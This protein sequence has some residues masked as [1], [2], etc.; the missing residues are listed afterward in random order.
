MKLKSPLSLLVL[1]LALVGLAVFTYAQG[2]PAQG[3]GGGGADAGGDVRVAMVSP[4]RIFKA[5]RETKD[6]GESMESEGIRLR[7]EE[8]ERRAKI[9]RLQDIRN[10]LKPESAQWD[11]AQ[12]NLLKAA[13]D[14]DTWGK[15]TKAKAERNQKRQMKHLF[16]Q[17]ERAVAEVAERDGYDLVLADQRPKLDNLDEINF[18][19]LQALLT[20]RNVLYASAKADISD[21][22]IALLDAKY[23]GAAAAPAGGAGAGAAAP[24]A[25]AGAPAPARGKQNPAPRQGGAPAGKD[26]AA[27][28]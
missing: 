18:N 13:I 12:E 21:Q 3:G 8:D 2:Q 10:D 22:V 7:A 28:D 15:L 16:D 4:S 25:G 1:P 24:A 5:M 27:Q 11:E 23:K 6:L 19:Q 20:S 14:L 17:I 26:G 9:K